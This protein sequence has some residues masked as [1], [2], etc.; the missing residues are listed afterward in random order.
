MARVL[1]QPNLWSEVAAMATGLQYRPLDKERDWQFFME[2]CQVSADA[3]ATIRLLTEESSRAIWQVHVSEH[4]SERHNVIPLIP[5]DQWPQ[6]ETDCRVSLY[7]QDSWESG[8]P[9]DIQLQLRSNLAWEDDTIV[10]FLWSV[11]YGVET[12]WRT[13]LDY[14]INFLFDDECPILVTDAYDEVILFTPDG[15]LHIGEGKPKP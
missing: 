1:F 6:A 14:W 9:D 12:T 5:N 15:K 13:F 8:R 2:D 10:F 3:L 11:H 7:W 4:V